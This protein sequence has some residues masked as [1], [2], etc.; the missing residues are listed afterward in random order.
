M[1]PLGVPTAFCSRFTACFQ[2]S[3]PHRKGGVWDDQTAI[4]FASCCV[5][6][7]CVDT[8]SARR[9]AAVFHSRRY[10]VASI[11]NS[12]HP[13]IG[14]GLVV[15]V[16]GI[17]LSV[18]AILSLGSGICLSIL[19]YNAETVGAG[20]G[21]ELHV[22]RT[23]QWDPDCTFDCLY[24][25]RLFLHELALGSRH[26]P[27]VLPCYQRYAAWNSDE[28]PVLL[29]AAGRGQSRYAL[30]VLGTIYLCDWGQR[31]GPSHDWGQYYALSDR[32]LYLLRLFCRAFRGFNAGAR[33]HC[34]ASSNTTIIL[35]ALAALAFSGI[36][37]S[38]PYGRLPG[39]LIGTLTLSVLKMC[40]TIYAMP[41]YPD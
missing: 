8:D 31:T 14:L 15:L 16:G 26:F 32:H 25:D 33:F 24:R 10:P 36:R 40:M 35:E 22:L 38:R 21:F 6:A 37:F 4:L 34:N 18:G 17:D 5:D 20:G 12:R 27:D 2:C 11:G 13:V 3:P 28:R 29:A 30:H 39:L 19:V 9:R 1:L 7:V 23:D 41:P